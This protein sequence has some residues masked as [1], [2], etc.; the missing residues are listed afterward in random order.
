M[1]ELSV[2]SLVARLV[3]PLAER[4]DEQEVELLA[5]STVEV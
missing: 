1:V 4:M 5:A 2:V 3:D